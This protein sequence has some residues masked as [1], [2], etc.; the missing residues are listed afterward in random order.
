MTRY[1]HVEYYDRNTQHLAHNAIVSS[2]DEF[3]ALSQGRVAVIT[4]EA[5]RQEYMEQDF[6]DD[7]MFLRGT[8]R[9]PG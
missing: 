8:E 7:G 4:G 1:W 9:I 5:T 3:A 2:F 6:T